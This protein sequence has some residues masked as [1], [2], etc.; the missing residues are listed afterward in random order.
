LIFDRKILEPSNIKK[1]RMSTSPPRRSEGLSARKAANDQPQSSLLPRF[2]AE[3]TLKIL[4]FVLICPEHLSFTRL[5]LSAKE[6]AARSPLS[7][8]SRRNW[9]TDFSDVLRLCLWNKCQVDEPEAAALHAAFNS[10][11]LVSKDIGY[12][13]RNIFFSR[14]KWVLHC[15]SSFDAIKWVENHW[16]RDALWSMTDLRIEMQAL[17]HNM[18]PMYGTLVGF[19]NLMKDEHSLQKLSVEWI[20][21]KIEL[22]AAGSSARA[23][24]SPHKVDVSRDYGLERNS[25]GKRGR[26]N[27]EED[28]GT[29]WKGPG[30]EPEDWARREVILQSLQALREVREVRIEG[31]V[32]EAWA[33]HLEMA[34]SASIDA[35]IPE[36]ERH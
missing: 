5:A 6:R 25:E 34:I 3:I 12:E 4:R 24:W 33:K 32:T 28:D 7:S 14:N 26:E 10:L 22:Q 19:V 9:Q 2:P 11:C 27:W 13:A 35:E 30:S 36:F 18:V 15:T 29:L 8:W 16:G 21:S 31:T 20:V 17:R 1:Y 23:P